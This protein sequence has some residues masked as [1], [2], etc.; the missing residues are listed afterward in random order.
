MENFDYT[1]E[2]T[3]SF[4]EAVA[5]IEAKSKEKGFG[6]LHIHDVKATLASKGFDR[7][8]LKII[9]I[10][11]AKYASQVLT[12]DIKISLM[13]PCPIS[14]YVEGGKTYISTLRPKVISDFYPRADIQSMAE[15]VDRI[16]LSIVDE[17]K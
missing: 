12:K 14:V 1:V 11:N 6:V 17:S 2:T 15:E 8:P 16:V 13:L 4:D 3:K 9:E 5:A 10:C 7:E